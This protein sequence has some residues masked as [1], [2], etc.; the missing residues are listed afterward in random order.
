M[1]TKPKEHP[2]LRPGSA[3]R[4]G[5]GAEANFFLELVRLDFNKDN[6]KTKDLLFNVPVS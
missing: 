4:L 1:G 6:S 2:N 5:A 3:A